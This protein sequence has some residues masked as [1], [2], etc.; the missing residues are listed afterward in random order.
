MKSNVS[1]YDYY[2]A[3]MLNIYNNISNM[4]KEKIYDPK[5]HL[6]LKNII[7]SQAHFDNMIKFV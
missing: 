7:N 6:L 2:L 4:P 5:V 3:S 1:V